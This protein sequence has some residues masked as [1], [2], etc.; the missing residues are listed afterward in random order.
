[1]AQKK[2]GCFHNV[3]FWVTVVQMPKMGLFLGQIAGGI[4]KVL[5][6]R[7]WRRFFCKV[8]AYGHTIWADDK[9]GFSQMKNFDLQ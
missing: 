6:F 1:M 9:L 5:I 3:K 2:I 4:L 8:V 7:I